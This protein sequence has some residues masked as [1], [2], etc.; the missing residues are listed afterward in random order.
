MSCVPKPYHRCRRNR[1]EFLSAV[2]RSLS[3]RPSIGLGQDLVSPFWPIA[4]ESTQILRGLLHWV[5][6]IRRIDAKQL[7]RRDVH[8]PEPLKAH[9]LARL[10]HGREHEGW[11]VGRSQVALGHSQHGSAFFN[12]ISGR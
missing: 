5:A 3:N 2:E 9:A 4:Q 6:I 1:R 7:F 11:Y 8:L 12:G 10:L